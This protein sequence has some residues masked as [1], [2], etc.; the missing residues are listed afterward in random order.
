M[1]LPFHYK[2]E[3]GTDV[4]VSRDRHGYKYIFDFFK[5]GVM[6]D[7]FIWTPDAN[8]RSEDVGVSDLKSLTGKYLEAVRTFQ[9]NNGDAAKK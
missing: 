8:V 7:S 4:E 3:N 1:T 9:N 2:L 6:F 5:N